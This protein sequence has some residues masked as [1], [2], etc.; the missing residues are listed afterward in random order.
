MRVGF[1]GRMKVVEPLDAESGMSVARHREIPRCRYRRLLSASKCAETIL[2]AAATSGR[3]TWRG[4]FRDAMQPVGSATSLPKGKYALEYSCAAGA[5]GGEILEETDQRVKLRRIFWRCPM[6]T[7]KYVRYASR[8]FFA[9][10]VALD[11][12]STSLMR[13]RAGVDIHRRDRVMATSRRLAHQ[14]SRRGGGLNSANC[15]TWPR[16]SC[17]HFWEAA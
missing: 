9:Y 16:R 1:T 12:L 8:G 17:T 14:Y 2:G 11:S 10:D 13:R 15:R 4:L 5:V 6:S 7:K 3:A